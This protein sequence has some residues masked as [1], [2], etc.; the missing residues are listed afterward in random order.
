MSTSCFYYCVNATGAHSCIF[1]IAPPVISIRHVF[2][3]RP[4]AFCARH[5]S[6]FRL[7][8][9]L[10]FTFTARAAAANSVISIIVACSASKL[11]GA[12]Q[13]SANCLFRVAASRSH[14]T[15]CVPVSQCV[16]IFASDGVMMMI[17]ARSGVS[18]TRLSILSAASAMISGGVLLQ[19]SP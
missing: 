5:K 11:R 16:F 9:L 19:S 1:T 3:N 18:G 6:P 7:T 17:I 4:I 14:S 13:R 2:S 15:F 10:M 12:G 8:M